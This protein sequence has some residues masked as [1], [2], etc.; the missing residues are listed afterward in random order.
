MTIWNELA[1]VSHR[2][3]L[4]SIDG[5]TTRVLELGDPAAPPVVCLH[6]VGGHLEAFARNVI[7]LSATRR[8][9]AY[10]LPGHGYSDGPPDRSYEIDGYVAHLRAL[11]VDLG[12]GAADLVGVSLGGWVAAR[13]AHDHPA[14]VERL[15]LVGTGGATYDSAVM[16][17]IR[18]LSNAAVNDPSRDNVRQRLE[19]LMADPAAVTDELVEARQAIYSQAGFAARMDRVLC[20]QDPDTRRANLLPPDVWGEIAAPA[21]VVWG[22]HDRT[23]PLSKGREIADML[24]AGE[25][26]ALTRSGH[27]PQFESPNEFNA[28]VV[29]FL[30][31]KGHS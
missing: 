22:S 31:V 1:P 14:I 29:D 5:V 9:V 13:A 11:L 23:G 30:D 28:A 20:L 19:W 12:V 2:L 10:D 15:V 18:S 3:G 16:Q 21:L 24:P 27:W 17:S 26:L 8:V 4:R 7:A 25:F 6:G